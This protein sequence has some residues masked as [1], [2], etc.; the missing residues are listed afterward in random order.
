MAMAAE[1]IETVRG[2]EKEDETH[3]AIE[4]SMFTRMKME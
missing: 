4:I 1:M 3:L 2:D